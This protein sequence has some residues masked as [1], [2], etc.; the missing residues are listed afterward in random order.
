MSQQNDTGVISLIAGAALNQYD[1]VKMDGATFRQVIVTGAGDATIGSTRVAAESGKDIG[2]NLIKSKPGTIIAIADGVV[3]VNAD[4][5][6]GAAGTVSATILG[7]I[8]G[9]ALNAASAA[10]D[11]VEILPA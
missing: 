10:G 6:T 4:C 1:L 2:V 11:H 8:I 3:A 9:T 7:S 5:Y